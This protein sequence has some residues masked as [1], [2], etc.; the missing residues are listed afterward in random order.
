MLEHFFDW[1]PWVL[2]GGTIF[3]VKL[4]SAISEG[5]AQAREMQRQLESAA[6]RKEF[7]ERREERRERQERVAASRARRA[8]FERQKRERSG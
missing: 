4:W 5:R 7:P 8:E 1:K 3:G 2:I 6:K